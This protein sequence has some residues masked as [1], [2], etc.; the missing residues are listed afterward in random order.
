M[1]AKILKVTTTA[2]LPSV[3][4]YLPETC[5]KQILKISALILK[6]RIELLFKLK[7]FVFFN[8]FLNAANKLLIQCNYELNPENTEIKC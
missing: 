5:V 1:G 6:Y 7:F 2:Q 4:M 3:T 8:N